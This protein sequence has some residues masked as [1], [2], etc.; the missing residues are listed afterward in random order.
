MFKKE[1]FLK[2]KPEEISEIEKRRESFGSLSDSERGVRLQKE[3]QE[4]RLLNSETF[5]QKIEQ[6]NDPEHQKRLKLVLDVIETINAL[7][8][9]G[10]VVGG[11]A[12]DEV[13]RRLGYDV[14]SKDIDIEAYGFGFEDLAK[15]LEEKFGSFE[16][17]NK[18][19]AQ[20]K[21]IKL[22]NLL[23]ISIPRRDSK[24]GKGHKDFEIT[25]DPNMSVKE[26]ARRRDFT[27]NS[28]A[29]DPLTGQIIDEW[30]GIEDIGNK[31]LRATDLEL[32]KDD[33][34]RVFRA[35]QFAGRFGFMIDPKTAEVCR[36]IDLSDLPEERI[37]EEWQK[38][39]EK[40]PKPSL[41]LEAAREFG[42]VEK[43]YPELQALIGCGQEQEWHPEG[44]VWNHSLMAMDA[45]AEI[46]R[47]EK[48]DA[49]TRKVITLGA[50]CHDLGKPATTA[51]ED[52]RI[53]SKKHEQAG[54]APAKKFLAEIL[55]SVKNG[56]EI[57]QKVLPIVADHLYHVHNPNPTKN[58]LNRLAVR[59]SPATIQELLWVSEA[60][61]HGR[62]LEWNG[63]PEGEKILKLAK[64][65]QIEKSKPKPVLQGRDLIKLG[66]EPGPHFGQTIAK[67][68]EA[69]LDGQV[70]NYEE[71][72]EMARELKK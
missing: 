16:K 72:L 41:G 51:F 26:A 29:L 48:L 36:S 15:L 55:K 12:R 22:E 10:L 44:D 1:K 3:Q 11:Y 66:F 40:S 28:L 42:I 24:K 13:L 5:W 47:R 69:Q 25:G 37:S 54:V 63:F 57:I 61:H 31:T 33:P 64:E 43:N 19:G 38:L 68:Y 2:P 45:A 53:R 65:L 50:L 17:V 70:K 7:G 71:A 8:G 34:L 4:A 30:G 23:D 46:G 52:G 49:F 14:H 67:V 35:M 39:I 32:F 21:V 58:A 59:L 6:E 62:D 9:L 20:F 18:V 27:M 56:E 60:D